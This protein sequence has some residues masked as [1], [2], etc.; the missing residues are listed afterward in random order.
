MKV[1]PDIVVAD[2]AE[3]EGNAGLGRIADGRGHARIGHRDHHIGGH[4]RLAGELGADALARL[5]DAGALD[6]AVGPGEV[7]VFEDA[8]AARRGGEGAQ[9]MDAGAVEHDELA[10]LDVADELGA[11]DVQRAGL[12]GQDMARSPSLPSTSGRTPRGSRTPITM[13]WAS[14]TRE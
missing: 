3:L 9:R 10:R 14:A 2:D 4:A 6:D 13:S 1:R 7:D 11:D 8:E 5:I 12:R